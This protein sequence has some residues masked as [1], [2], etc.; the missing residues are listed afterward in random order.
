MS[1][2]LKE[3]VAQRKALDENIAAEQQRAKASVLEQVKN[4]LESVGMQP[5]DAL[6]SLVKQSKPSRSRVS[7]GT[8]KYRHTPTGATWTGNG[9]VPKWYAEGSPE[10]ET[11]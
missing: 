10:V 7:K 8:P 5:A 6:A 1:E 9:R 3:L 11:L 2:Y 4:L